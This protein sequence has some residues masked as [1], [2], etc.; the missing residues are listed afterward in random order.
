[1]AGAVGLRED[2]VMIE[3][4][5]QQPSEPPVPGVVVVGEPNQPAESQPTESVPSPAKVMR[6]GAMVRQ[7]LEEVRH[8]PL[9]EAGRDR[10]REIYDIS[11]RELA[12]SLSPDLAEELGRVARPFTGDETPSEAELRVAQAQ[13]VGWL[14]GLFHGIQAT[15]FAQQVN[16]RNQLEEMR[17]RALPGRPGPDPS[18]QYL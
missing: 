7:L 17:R 13:L 5:S 1:V 15:L 11:V 10:M 9:D 16:A 4:P 2:A 12:D 6:I 8:A 14:E 18:G 3:Q